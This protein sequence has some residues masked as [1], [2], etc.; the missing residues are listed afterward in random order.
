MKISKIINK[1]LY[2][3]TYSSKAYIDHIR[4]SGGGIGDNCYIF[5]PKTVSIDL[6]R[7]YLLDIGS[8]VVIC[9]KTT[10]LTHDYSHTV[11]SEKY[12]IN[13]GD[14]KP[15]K[16]GNNVFIGIGAMILMGSQIGNN[17]IIGAQSVVHGV[18]PDNS[19]VAGN[20]AKIICTLDEYYNKRIQNEKKCAIQ[21]VKLAE[22]KMGRIPTV[23]EMG[24]AFAWL[25]LPRQYETIKKYPEFFILPGK[26]KNKFVQD[27]MRSQPKYDSYEDFIKK[28]RDK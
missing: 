18:I 15:V 23:E 13:I 25:Y 10:I 6:F 9:A 24:D 3:K 19:V 27:F 2:P 21:N 5:D 14:A 8:N 4:R 20:P 7:P 1:F 28:I 12:N 16:I 17:V 26:E 22:E 11:L